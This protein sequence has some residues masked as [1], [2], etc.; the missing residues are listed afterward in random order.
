MRDN[1]QHSANFFW[2]ADP[3]RAVRRHQIRQRLVTSE[4]TFVHHPF[5]IARETVYCYQPRVDGVDT[6]TLLHADIRHRL[7]KFSKATRQ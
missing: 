1:R 4:T 2:L 5:Y 6:Q 7:G 3:G